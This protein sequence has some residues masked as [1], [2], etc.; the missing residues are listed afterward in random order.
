[1][2]RFARAV[3][4]LT[5]VVCGLT[6][7]SGCTVGPKYQRPPVTMPDAWRMAPAT[8][9]SIGDSA[10]WEVLKDAA[11]QDLIRTA[12]SGNT[13]V[14][15]AA[16][17]VLQSEA[18]LR[19]ARANEFPEV[20]GTGGAGR[21]RGARTTVPTA[22][23]G[24]TPA[25]TSEPPRQRPRRRSTPRP[26]ASALLTWWISGDSTRRATE[27]ARAT[28]LATREAQM[29]VAITV[30]S[31]VAQAYFD[32][33]ALD[34][35]LEV[36]GRTVATLQESQRLT[37]VLFQGGVSSELDV[38]Q[39]ESAVETAQANMPVLQRQITQ[40]ENAINVLLGRNPAD[41]PRG[42][43]I[44]DQVLPP[45]VP[46]G[47]PSRLLERRPDIRQAENTLA[48]AFAGV[49]VAQAQLFPQFR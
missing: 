9:T 46:A 3:R 45:D 48:A 14:R 8:T 38:R 36:T 20:G 40:Q 11:L 12:L 30:V 22:T 33:R 29:N 49:G 10:W 2:D 25:T 27:Q 32:L 41:V 31:S 24:I 42:I 44:A 4:R 37:D 18:Q 16:N 47:L 6:V 17:R 26:S 15:L 39:A 28:L 43:A 5:L 23:G 21:Q 35:Q 19:I 13:D 34:A 1:M 7:T